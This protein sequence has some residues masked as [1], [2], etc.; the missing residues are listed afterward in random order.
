MVIKLSFKNVYEFLEAGE[1][2]ENKKGNLS[3]LRIHPSLG[4]LEIIV[5]I[6]WLRI[7]VE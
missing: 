1:T 7:M 2:I 6:D 3:E 4:W 5:L